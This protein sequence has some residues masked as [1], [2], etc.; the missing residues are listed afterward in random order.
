MLEYMGAAKASDAI[1][2]LVFG[3]AFEQHSQRLANASIIHFRSYN[4]E[5]RVWQGT[6]WQPATCG[7]GIREFISCG[8]IECL[9]ALQAVCTQVLYSPKR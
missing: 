8:Q 9:V 2:R 7:D 1:L 3:N 5:F 6:V 4:K